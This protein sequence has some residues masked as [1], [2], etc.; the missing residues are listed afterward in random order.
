MAVA[1]SDDGIRPARPLDVS[2]FGQ[3]FLV[4]GVGFGDALDQRLP[5]GRVVLDPQP[6]G[7]GVEGYRLGV[8]AG[9]EVAFVQVPADDEAGSPVDIEALADMSMGIRS[10]S[11]SSRLR[12]TRVP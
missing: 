1:A 6:E 2:P 9:E 5:V 12:G 4:P 3:G 8:A 10:G 11:I 7:R